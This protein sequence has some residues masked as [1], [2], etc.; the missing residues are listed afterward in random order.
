MTP[1][2][3]HRSLQQSGLDEVRP[4]GLDHR[5]DPLLTAFAS[6]GL[7]KVFGVREDLNLTTF[8]VI[9]RGGMNAGTSSM[10]C[11]AIDILLDA[12]GKGLLMPADGSDAIAVPYQPG[13]VYAFYTSDG[14]RGEYDVP[15]GARF[16]GLDIRVGTG[17][18]ER[19]GALD[20]LNALKPEHPLHIASCPGCWVGVIPLSPK[21]AEQARDILDRAQ[22]GEDDLA[23]EA[24]CLDIIG[25]TLAA[26]RKPALPAPSPRRDRRRLDEARDLMLADLARPWTIADLARRAGLNEKRLKTG[27]REAFGKPVYRFLQEARLDEARRLLVEEQCSVTDAALSVGYSSASRFTT[28]FTRQ[29]GVLPSS[30]LR[31]GRGPLSR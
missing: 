20:L 13:V 31:A 24:R 12:S 29:F 30:L 14:A 6:G 16:R 18:L 23:L 9:V 19:L 10:P 15:I 28:L 1:D 4:V 25:A 21:V 8:D 3:P 7:F 5:D 11:L 27:F 17:L 2:L 26:L 22:D